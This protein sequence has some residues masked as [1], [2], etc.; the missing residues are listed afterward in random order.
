VCVDS[1]A[2]SPP[3][4]PDSESVHSSDIYYCVLRACSNCSFVCTLCTLP[5]EMGGGGGRGRRPTCLAD[6]VTDL[7]N[8]R[9]LIK[10]VR[11]MI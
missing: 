11:Q 10:S 4:P 8:Y 3:K 7:S 9:C 6:S 5:E 1:Y 2:S